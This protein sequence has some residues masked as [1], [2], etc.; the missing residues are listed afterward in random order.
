VTRVDDVEP[1]LGQPLVEKLGVHR[2]H[3]SV[4]RAGDD[5][6]GRLD[7]RQQIAEGRKLRRVRAHVPHRLDE[8][9]ALVAGKVVLADEVG[10]RVPLN[11]A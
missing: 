9:V 1:A 2:R 6:Y 7:L 11:A 8:A 10:K 4:S 3:S 5:L